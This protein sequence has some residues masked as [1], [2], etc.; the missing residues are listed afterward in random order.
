MKKF[1]I[2]RRIPGIG[3]M[4]FEEFKSISKA[5]NSVISVMSKPYKWIESFVTGDKLYCVHEAESEEVVREHS[6]CGNFP[7]HSIEEIKETIGPATAK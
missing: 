7:I 4:S 1:L 3:N 6:K 5:S 2:E